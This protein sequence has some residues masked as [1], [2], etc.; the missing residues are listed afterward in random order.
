MIAVSLNRIKNII[1]N[2]EV[3]TFNKIK[4]SLQ[5]KCLERTQSIVAEKHIILINGGVAV[6]KSTVAY[7]LFK[8]MTNGEIFFISHDAVFYKFF[9][10]NDLFDIGYDIARQFKNSKLEECVL[11]GES[12]VWETV[13]SKDKKNIY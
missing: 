8:H 6:G 11:G 12:F 4:Y 7:N 1:D 13:L 9:S 2:F 5:S 3:P 10:N